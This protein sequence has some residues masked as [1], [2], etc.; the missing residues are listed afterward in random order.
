MKKIIVPAKKE[1]KDRKRRQRNMRVFMCRVVFSFVFGFACALAHVSVLHGTFYFSN[2]PSSIALKETDSKVILNNA[3]KV[4]GW[5]EFSINKTFGKQSA[6]SWVENYPNSVVISQEGSQVPATQL[7]ISDSN[8]INYG[9]KNNSNAILAYENTVSPF[10][11][12]E[13]QQLVERVQTDS[14]VFVSCCKN[15]SNA[16]SYGL[17]NNSSA[18]INF[19]AGVFEPLEKQEFLEEIRTTSH[20]FLYCC[21]NT[22]NAISYGLKNNSSALIALEEEFFDIARTTSNAFAYCCKN[23]SNALS[24]GIKNNSN[25]ILTARNSTFT[26]LEKEELVETARTTSNAFLYCCKNTSNALSYGIKNN[27]N[28]LI[29]LQAGYFELI[30]TTSNAFAYCC[31]NNSNA[32]IFGIRNNS[33]ALVNWPFG[34]LWSILEKRELYETIRVNSNAFL[35]CCKNTSNAFVSTV[36]IYDDHQIYTADTTEENF[37]F[38]K[39]GFTVSDGKT[40]TL[41]TPTPISGEINLS[42]TGILS[43]DNDL[44]IAS[45]SY[46]TNGGIVDGNGNSFVLS[47]NFTIPENQVLQI[48]SDTIINGHGTTIILEPHAQITVD[49]NVTLTIKNARIRNTRNSSGDPLISILGGS[50]KLALQNCELALA[51]DYYF[52]QGHLFIH[53]DVIISGTSALRYTSEAHSYIAHAATWYFDKRS[54]LIYDTQNLENNLIIL[55]SKTA[56]MYLD[57]A[58]LQAGD[59]GLR[60]S[61]GRLL[62]DNNVTFSCPTSMIIFGDSSKIDIDLQVHVLADARV[63]ITGY[64]FDDSGV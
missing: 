53:D 30:R 2:Y 35:Y 46:L 64:V 15:T 28:A 34:A 33:N 47:C 62:L 32:L 36:R 11:A 31:K 61:T 44:Y 17:K 23:T 58:T 59:M 12:L 39:A 22:S 4:I 3:S 24:Y 63:E 26:A 49:N 57:G 45:N 14:Y 9:L 56:C 18:I 37:V 1:N 7:V 8:A 50:G 54:K 51:D 27:S 5:S 20:A 43:L 48:T 60:L 6:D 40:L 10:T 41:N 25:T 19:Y 16:L 52:D 21:E 42:D 29:P 13:H 55:Q 38:Y